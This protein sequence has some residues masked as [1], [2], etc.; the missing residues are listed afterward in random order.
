MSVAAA[1]VTAR[2]V[3]D[4]FG[5]DEHRDIYRSEC[6]KLGKADPGPP[7]PPTSSM[8]TRIPSATG[9]ARA[10]PTYGDRPLLHGLPTA[11]NL[12]DV[13]FGGG[14]SGDPLYRVMAPNGVC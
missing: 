11:A 12:F 2:L 5:R 10:L 4:S 3:D 7:A 1:K 13:S 8:S 14:A 6:V 9:S